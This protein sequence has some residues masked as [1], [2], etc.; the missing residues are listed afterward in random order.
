MEF[1][2]YQ[3]LSSRTA[4]SDEK[5]RDL[6]ANFA[7]GLAGEAGEVA[8]LIKKYRFHGHELKQEDLIKELGD[9]LW[10]ASLIAQ[11]AAISFNEV[12]ESNI[13][14]LMT[15]YPDGFNSA[16]SIKRVDVHE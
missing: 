6:L 5:G 8:D 1:D 16:D 10:Y 9:V 3:E 12:A 4:N 7:L 15:R 11:L 14:K 13:A 2:T